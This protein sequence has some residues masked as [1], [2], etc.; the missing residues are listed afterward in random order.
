MNSEHNEIRAW[1]AD[2]KKAGQRIDPDNAELGCCT[3][4][5][6]DPYGV[7]PDLSEELKSYTERFSF[8]RSPDGDDGWVCF[9]DLPEPTRKELERKIEEGETEEVW[10]TRPRKQQANPVGDE[11]R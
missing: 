2:R 7:W 5:S 3:C 6:M 9:D 8:A 4:F 1:L 10:R 11:N